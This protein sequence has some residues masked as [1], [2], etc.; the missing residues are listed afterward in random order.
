MGSFLRIPARSP[1][2][3]H[4]RPWQPEDLPCPNCRGVGEVVKLAARQPWLGRDAAL[5]L[6][7][8]VC[9]ACGGRSHWRHP[10]AGDW[11]RLA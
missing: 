7:V 11:G 10:E 9:R 1:E 6:G 2:A 5:N 8:G 4:V 3:L